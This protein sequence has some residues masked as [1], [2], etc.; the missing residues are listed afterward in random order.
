M[1]KQAD[2]AP[3]GFGHDADF[4]PPRGLGNAHV[5]TILGSLWPRKMLVRWRSRAL[6]RASRPV[7]LTCRD[8]IRLLGE[9]SPH[10]NPKRGLAILIHGWEGSANSSYLLS[11]ATTLY[12]H[13][14]SVFRLNLR[15]HGPSH[16]LNEEP[17]LAV[18]LEEV[19]DAAEQIQQ[20]FPHEHF[21]LGGFS[22]GGNFAIRIAAHMQDHALRFTRV[23]AVCPPI[24]T[25]RSIE[26]VSR[27]WFYNR[28]FSAKW[29]RS[30]MKKAA[31]FPRHQ[32]N[33]HLMQSGN[34]MAMHKAFLPV[35]SKYPDT[36]S[37]FDAIRLNGAHIPRLGAPCTIIISKDDPVIPYPAHRD[38][39][40]L[41]N[42]TLMVTDRGGH[43]SFLKDYALHS[44][45]DEQFEKLFR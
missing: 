6:R 19:L 25:G 34:L 8:N 22:L 5:N 24:D 28:Y 13:G 9:Y 31:L 33:T 39:P 2:I 14:F 27:S 35:Y 17:F 42:L 44:W 37:Y 43:C 38:L 7:E 21:W 41:D 29:R 30:F 4:T 16:H 20:L 10:P 1:D 45:V 32:S 11:A 3:A 40:K 18:R 12:Q 23:V 26:S 15:D 36:D